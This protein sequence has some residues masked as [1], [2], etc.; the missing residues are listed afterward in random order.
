[1]RIDIEAWVQAEITAEYEQQ[2]NYAWEEY[3][4]RYDCP[5]CNN[6]APTINQLWS[7]FLKSKQ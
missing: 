2:I 4:N 3:H 1:M 7:D 6:N 5:C